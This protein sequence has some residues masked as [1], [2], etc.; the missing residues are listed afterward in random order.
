MTKRRLM[1]TS[2]KPRPKV[3]GVIELQRA[4]AFL[5][6]LANRR[7]INQLLADTI[8]KLHPQNPQIVDPA[9]RIKRLYPE[10]AAPFGDDFD[11]WVEAL[12]WTQIFLRL[13]WTAVDDR[14][15]DWYLYEMRRQFRLA[16]IASMLRTTKTGFAEPTFFSEVPGPGSHLMHTDR[17]LI[18]PPEITAF[19]AAAYHFQSR[20]GQRARRCPREDCLSPYFIA[21]PANAK[22]YCSSSC[23]NAGDKVN[24]NKSYLRKKAEK[25][26]Q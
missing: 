14:H 5:L 19:E 1:G 24:K 4:E 13:A 15:R 9:K 22:K 17:S 12:Y 16:V 10:I 11:M 8:R 26:I 25:R 3:L 7:P 18:E 6:D 20:I 2:E 23:A 21:P